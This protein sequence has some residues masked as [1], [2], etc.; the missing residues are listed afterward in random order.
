MAE[1][2][3]AGSWQDRCADFSFLICRGQ[4]MSFSSKEKEALIA[5]KGVGETVIKRFE[6]VGIESFDQLRKCEVDDVADLVSSMLNTTCW[7]N[8]PQARRAIRQSIER[9]RQPLF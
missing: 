6:Q 4:T 1:I 9:A 2:S 5:V 8:S 7:K 3:E